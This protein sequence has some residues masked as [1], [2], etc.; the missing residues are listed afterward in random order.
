MSD[1]ETPK[2]V[3]RA[4][5]SAAIAQRQR[6]KKRTA[7]AFPPQASPDVGANPCELAVKPVTCRAH[8]SDYAGNHQPSLGANPAPGE[9]PARRTP[10]GVA[11]SFGRPQARA[12]AKALSGY[13]RRE[14]RRV[15]PAISKSQAL[16]RGGASVESSAGDEID[17]HATRLQRDPMD[18]SLEQCALGRSGDIVDALDETRRH[19][20]ATQRKREQHRAHVTDDPFPSRSAVP[21]IDDPKEAGEEQTA[22][23]N[24][25]R[26]MPGVGIQSEPHLRG[27]IATADPEGKR[28]KY[29]RRRQ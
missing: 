6:R 13:E 8:P 20:R 9:P 29:R 28:D 21:A 4:S 3:A 5:E 16:G 27:A 22:T 11:T 7:G 2:R 17:A 19:G 10:T 18:A 24:R 15:E 23:Q 26:L 12:K 14:W 25:Q 1:S